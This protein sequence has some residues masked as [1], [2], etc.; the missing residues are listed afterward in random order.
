MCDGEAE[1]V[2]HNCYSLRESPQRAGVL[3]A[4]NRVGDKK[5]R[6]VKDL[7]HTL[8]RRLT[9][10]AEQ[11]ENPVIRIEDFEHI[12]ENSSWSGVHSWHFHQLQ[13]FII[14]N[15]EEGE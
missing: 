9:T 11:F 12:R 13:D 3:R 4:R 8:S 14:Y 6:Q 2:R 5:Q 10:F 15:T 1:Y 7:N